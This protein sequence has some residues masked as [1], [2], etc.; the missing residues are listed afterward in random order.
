M[1]LLEVLAMAHT[2]QKLEVIMLRKFL[3]LKM[4]G[5]LNF[6]MLKGKTD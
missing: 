3:I 4:D 5:I 2:A 6:L 1:E